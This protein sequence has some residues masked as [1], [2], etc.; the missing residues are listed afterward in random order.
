ML[1][2]LLVAALKKIQ[3]AMSYLAAVARE[4]QVLCAASLTHQ[5]GGWR[6]RSCCSPGSQG[7]AGMQPAGMHLARL[8]L[9]SLGTLLFLCSLGCRSLWFFLTPLFPNSTAKWCIVAVR[10]ASGTVTSFSSALAIVFSSVS[11]RHAPRRPDEHNAEQVRKVWEL[12]RFKAL[13]TINIHAT[14]WVL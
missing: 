6:R 11:L 9:L 12:S 10:A 2:F 7:K 14:D 13:S 1:A 8:S 4:H 5:I 3:K